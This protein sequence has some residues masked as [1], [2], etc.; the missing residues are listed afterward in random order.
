MASVKYNFVENPKINSTG[1][2]ITEGKYKDIIYYYR[3]ATAP[4]ELTVG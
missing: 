4:K 1:F 3:E 2:Q